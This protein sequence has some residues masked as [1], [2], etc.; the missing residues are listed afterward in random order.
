M[1]PLVTSA[2]RDQIT[3]L[4]RTM[5]CPGK[6]VSLCA[7][8]GNR[9]SHGGAV[10]CVPGSL[11]R[12]RPARVIHHHRF[13]L[14][15]RGYDPCAATP[16]ASP[17]L[18]P[19]DGRW[20]CSPARRAAPQAGRRRRARGHAACARSARRRF[21]SRSGRARGRARGTCSALRNTAR[22]ARNLRRRHTT[23]T[24]TTTARP[25]SAPSHHRAA[26]VRV[27]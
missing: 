10:F 3:C 23:A 16:P 4:S 9:A 7:P 11:A 27:L 21:G 5:M 18:T 6:S 22:S 13:A 2:R 17:P 12:R 24:T 14:H 25:S 15:P 1:G 8:R 19:H 20:S 26:L